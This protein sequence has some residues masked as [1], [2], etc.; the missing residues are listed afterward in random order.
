[1]CDTCNNYFARKIEQPL[2]QSRHFKNLRARQ[3]IST[4]RGIIPPEEGFVPECGVTVDLYRLRD[5][6]KVAAAKR[7]NEVP[8]EL[9][10]IG[11][12]NSADD[13]RF[14]DHLFTAKSGT[15]LLDRSEPTPDRLLARLIAKVALEAVAQRFC[16][17][18]GWRDQILAPHFDELRR[19]V[20][21]GDRPPDW[22]I[23]KRRLYEEDA[24]VS[25]VDG[26][27]QTVHE[28]QFLYTEQ[29]ELYGVVCIFGV[30][31]AINLGGPEID[32]YRQWLQ[33][34]RNNSVLYPDGLGLPRLASR[35]EKP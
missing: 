30:E 35:L 16:P 31:Y 1:M 29:L 2:L 4:K 19:F 32:G 8:V 7:R 11:A 24:V 34:H 3:A 17:F 20:R 23:H 5:R 9:M 6:K 25:T 14:I 13:A 15:V 28:Y 10:S 21:I 26:Y 18:E 12:K 22:P 27:Q 33:L